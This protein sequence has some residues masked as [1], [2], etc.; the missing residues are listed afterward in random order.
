MHK[1]EPLR[2]KAKD[3]SLGVGV[4][5]GEGLSSFESLIVM[6]DPREKPRVERPEV[7]EMGRKWYECAV[8]HAE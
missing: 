1:F 4:G 6:A 5:G 7:G 8:A 2:K 3:D